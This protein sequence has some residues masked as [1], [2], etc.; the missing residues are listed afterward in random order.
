MKYFIL[1]LLD[2]GRFEIGG[3]V[4]KPIGNS[5]NSI[6]V[7]ESEIERLH[8]QAITNIDKYINRK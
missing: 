4:D 2:D 7:S 3:M 1:R 6:I 5:A 8:P